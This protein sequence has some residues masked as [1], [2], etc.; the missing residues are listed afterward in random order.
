MLSST[1]VNVAREL[2]M[3]ATIWTHSGCRFNLAMGEEQPE[4]CKKNSLNALNYIKANRP[5]YVILSQALSYEEPVEELVNSV[6]QVRVLGVSVSVI[7][8][9]PVLANPNFNR[10]GSFLI[11]NDQPLYSISMKSLDPVSIALREAYIKAIQ[12][13]GINMIDPFDVLCNKTT[14][15]LK[16]GQLQFFRDNNHLTPAGAALL[17]ELIS[18]HL[19]NLG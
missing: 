19:E 16:K 9:I 13:S 18:S 11:P 3:K 5:S 7:T 10:K 15:L 14:C 1:L 17:E 4:N 2:N 12:R 8:P 6:K